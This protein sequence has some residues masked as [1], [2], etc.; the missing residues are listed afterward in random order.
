MKVHCKQGN[1]SS[2]RLG[3][4]CRRAGGQSVSM[5]CTVHGA[6]INGACRDNLWTVSDLTLVNT[7]Y[8][9]KAL[10]DRGDKFAL[11]MRSKLVTIAAVEDK[12]VHDQL[13]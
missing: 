7:V 6:V 11:E 3:R 2:G 5:S 9:A 10:T 13:C 4:Q 8:S 1:Q 12:Q